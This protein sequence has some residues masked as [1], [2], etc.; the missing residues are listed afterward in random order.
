VKTDYLFCEINNGVGLNCGSKFIDDAVLDK[1]HPGQGP[2]PEFPYLHARMKKAGVKVFSQETLSYPGPLSS[3]RW[4]YQTDY[5]FWVSA[6]Q[7]DPVP[8][9]D[10][11]L[12]VCSHMDGRFWTHGRTTKGTYDNAVGTGYALKKDKLTAD[13]KGLSNH[14]FWLAPDASYSRLIASPVATK[15]PFFLWKTLPD[16]QPVWWDG[17]AREDSFLVGLPGGGYGLARAGGRAL[18]VD[19]FI[20]NDLKTK[21]A[22]GSLVWASAVEP[23]LTSGASGPADGFHAIAFKGNG[24]DVVEGVL[25]QGALV[26]TTVD[27]ARTPPPRPGSPAPRKGFTTVFTRAEDRAFVLGGTALANSAP[28][29]DIWM[30]PV[31]GAGE[32]SEVVLDNFTL[33]DVLAATWSYRDHRLWVLDER[34]LSGNNIARLV[35]IDIYR[36]LVTMVGEWTRKSEFQRQWLWLDRDGVVFLAATS[37]NHHAIAR[38]LVPPLV[39]PGTIGVTMAID[40]HPLAFAPIADGDGYSLPL[41]KEVEIEQAGDGDENEQN[42]DDPNKQGDKNDKQQDKNDKA[43]ND[44]KAKKEKQSEKQEALSVERAATLELKQASLSDVAKML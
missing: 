38:F 31:D 19:P 12:H 24:T 36:G 22:D 20:G 39:A 28:L 25:R 1:V 16:P 6:N 29:H 4:L 42:G 9:C 41:I 27:F 13:G 37:K 21:L 17:F 40:P 2:N 3:R 32:W 23:F 7:I 11:S 5:S 35:R 26:G 33:G 34:V 14:Y 30:R 44:K 8:G 43:K 18:A 10:P 15:P